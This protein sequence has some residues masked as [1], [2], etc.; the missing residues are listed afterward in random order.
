MHNRDVTGALASLS[1]VAKLPY[2]S[3][4]DGISNTFCIV[5][6]ALGK[7]DN[8][9]ENL[10]SL[11]DGYFSKGSHHI[12]VNVLNRELLEDAHLHPEKYPNLTIRVSGY[13]VRFNQLTSEQR[14]EVLK[15][16]MHGTGVANFSKAGNFPSVHCDCKFINTGTSASTNIDNLAG[17]TDVQ[18][19][20]AILGAVHS[21]ETF[22]TCDGP[23]IRS[24]VFLQGCAKRCVFCSNPETQCIVDPINCEEVA[25]SDVDLACTIQKYQQFLK[26]NNGGITMSGGEP[27][28]QPDFVRAV[29]DRVHA[30]GL[31]TCLDTAGHGNEEMWDKVL[32]S[33]DHVLLCVKAMDPDL[34][35]FISGISKQS[36]ERSKTF[37]KH[38]RDKYPNIPLTF[39]KS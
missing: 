30:L 39:E 37:A 23:G 35:A 21:I 6:S 33:T 19:K 26:P 36:A 20:D 27:L 11:L 18:S 32:P 13:A 4:M 16:T 22:S 1:S 5:P 10:V 2:K 28:L 34:N 24:L 7:D 31:S 8:K 17:A 9:A 38:I 14:E 12:N 3:C 29:F 15:R 25:V